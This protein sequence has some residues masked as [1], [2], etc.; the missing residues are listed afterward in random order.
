[1]LI[2]PATSGDFDA[3]RNVELASFETLKNAGAVSGAPA[4][5]TDQELNE[6]LRHGLL[7]VACDQKSA[8]VGYCGGYVVEN[9]LHIGEM[10]VHPVC[11]RKGLGR[12][13]LTTLLDE[14][15]AKKLYGATLTTDRLAP[16]NAP[17]YAKYGFKLLEQEA[18][19]PRLRRIL[20]AEIDK[21]LD[22]SR[23]VAMSLSF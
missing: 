23:R 7:Y 3:L 5:S 16:F 17:F 12:S 1:M 11:Q 4:A 9:L 22:P 19:S 20:A 13:L 18:C 14:G 15:R 2:R 8:V 6:Y 10:D 21:G